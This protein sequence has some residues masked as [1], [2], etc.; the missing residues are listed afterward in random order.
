MKITVLS[1]R[2]VLRNPRRSLAT[3]SAA[4]LSAAAI[5]L[6]GGFTASVQKL[7]E[8][9]IVRACGHM[10]IYARGYYEFGGAGGDAPAISGYAEVLESLENSAGLKELAT[11][12]TPVQS[13]SGIASNFKA[14]ASRVFRGLGVVP[15]E[16]TALDRWNSYNIQLY[17]LDETPGVA[18]SDL[19]GGIIG[20]GLARILGLCA[21][22]GIKDCPA[23]PQPAEPAGPKTDFSFLDSELVQSRAPDPRPRIDLIAATQ[24]GAPNVVDF[25]INKAMTLGIKEQNDSF[26]GLHLSRAQ[27]LLYG[28]GEKKASGIIIQLKD[29]RDLARAKKIVAALLAA[30]RPDLE[31]LDYETLNPSYG[32]AIAMLDTIFAFIAIIMGIIVLFTVANTMSMSV[33]ERTAEI[34]TLR[35]LGLKQR[36]IIRMFLTEGVILGAAG[37]TTGVALAFAAAW[38]INLSKI[39]WTPPTFARPVMFSVH[40]AL[41]PLLAPLCWAGL[42]GL[43]ALSAYLAARHAAKMKITDALRHV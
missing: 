39:M 37:A 18:D 12:V 11:M 16:Y 13:V 38:A 32:Q 8:T 35:A 34:G 3:V 15:S 22:L 31:A 23:R 21:E 9:A 20:S 33:V 42:V 29:T 27:E 1:A 4:A 26:A 6:F 40:P 17:E 7:L 30:T 25:Y 10:Q 2:N 5:L 19:N 41:F 36:H 43:S 24:H 28:R 14:D